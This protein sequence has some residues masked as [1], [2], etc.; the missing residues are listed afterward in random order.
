MRGREVAG[1]VEAVG[2]NVTT[3]QVGDEVFGIGEGCF[4]EYARA[5]PTSWRPSRPS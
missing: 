3:F 2:A 4:A 5:G 1:R